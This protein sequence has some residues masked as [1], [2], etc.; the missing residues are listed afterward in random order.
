[1]P[2]DTAPPEWADSP[3]KDAIKEAVAE[4]LN[5][6]RELIQEIVEDALQEMALAEALREVEAHERRFGR[7]P[8]FARV[9][10]EA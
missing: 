3:L 9:E 7:R 4:A 2:T 5:E 1:M 8:G 6:Q 10:G